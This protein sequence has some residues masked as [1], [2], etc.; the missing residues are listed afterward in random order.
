MHEYCLR[1]HIRPGFEVQSRL[2]A[3]TLNIP[4]CMWVVRRANSPC[5]KFTGYQ[6]NTAEKLLWDLAVGLYHMYGIN[7][8]LYIL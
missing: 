7:V 1:E 5:K 3:L 2:R 4:P 8:C 6:T